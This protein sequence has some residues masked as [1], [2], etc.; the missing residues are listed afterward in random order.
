MEKQN[1]NGM[2]R[3]AEV[4]RVLWVVMLLNITVSLVKII[5]GQLTGTASVEAD[6]IHS[7]FDGASNAVGLVGLFIAAR[8]ADESH[9]YGHGKYEA[10]ASAGIGVLLL[11]AAYEVGR[12]AVEALLSG[13]H[14][15]V[16]SPVALGVMVATIII[17]ICATTY[18]R[19]MGKKYNSTLLGAD[20][21]H[22]LSDALV[23]GS[24]IVGLLFV[25]AGFPV[26]DSIA[27]LVV[28]VAIFAAALSVFK[29]VHDAF[30][31]E[32]RIEPAQVAEAAMR[33]SQV[34]A[35]HK[36][37]TRGM[38]GEVYADLHVLVDPQLSVVDAHAAASA[39]EA[40][41]KGDFPQV[42]EVL[43]HVEPDVPAE[44][45]A[46]GASVATIQVPCGEEFV[47][48]VG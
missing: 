12:P 8:P 13:T 22:T 33:V 48:A 24:V 10:F 2:A 16:F 5:V 21:K 32:A 45:M 31:D 4:R 19:T 9:P 14:D 28:T 15:T 3:G 20:A 40:A 47:R 29:E 37:R 46:A 1:E 42:A 23:S 44:R 39:V 25:A 27:A 7:I 36:V 35:C 41:I 17:N 6:G 30:S 38:E 26:A 34:R 11:L 43:V 18:E